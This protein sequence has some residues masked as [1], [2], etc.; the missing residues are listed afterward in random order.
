MLCLVDQRA[1]GLFSVSCHMK[2]WMHNR[3]MSNFRPFFDFF[4]DLSEVLHVNCNS[5]EK[6]CPVFFFWPICVSYLRNNVC[7]RTVFPKLELRRR[8][9]ICKSLSWNE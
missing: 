1:T 9:V 4:S 8:N 7:K 6:H 5:I 3:L 2:D